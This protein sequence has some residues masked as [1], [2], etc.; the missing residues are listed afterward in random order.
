MRLVAMHHSRC[1]WLLMPLHR[2]TTL[3]LGSMHHMQPMP[4]A[5]TMHYI[6]AARHEVATAHPCWAGCS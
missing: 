6:T 3:Q 1:C 4:V 5:L 2:F